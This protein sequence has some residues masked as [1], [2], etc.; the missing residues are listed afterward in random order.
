M[1]IRLAAAFLGLCLLA[2]PAVAKDAKI[3]PTTLNLIPPPGYCEMDPA[4]ASDAR[5]V[6]AI[7]GM[8]GNTGNR[9]LAVSADCN[10]LTNWRTGKRKL[11]DNMAQYQTIIS[12]ESSPLPAAPDVT[13]KDACNQMRAQGEQLVADMT[14]DVQARAE[15]VL[16]TVK[17]NEMKFL[18]VVGEDPLVCYAAMLQKFKTEVGTD[19]TQVTVFATTVIKFKIVYY[20]LFAPYV[21]G[22]TVTDMLAQQRKNVAALQAANPE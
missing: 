10:Q 7:E 11:L 5:M 20:Y 9:L 2:C 17:V 21:S 19:K 3:G 14:P 22:A 16:K 4:Q 6:K 15:Q 8:L 12:L 18:G 13:I 1:M